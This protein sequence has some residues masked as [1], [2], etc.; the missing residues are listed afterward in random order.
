ML[1]ARSIV[2][3]KSVKAD[4]IDRATASEAGAYFLASQLGN[5]SITAKSMELVY[6][7]PNVE[8]NIPALYV[9]NTTDRH[10]FVIV[11]G[12]DCVMPIIAYSTD[13]CF[14]PNNIPPNMQWW[15]DG[16]VEDIVI[17]QNNE[18]EPAIEARESWEEL[19]EQR[20]PYFGSNSKAIIRLTTSTWNQ[21]PLYNNMCPVLSGQ[22]CVTGCVATAMAQILYYWKYPYVGKLSKE[23]SWHGQTLSANFANSYYNYDIMVD[24]LTSSSTTAQI[25]AVALLSYHCGISVDMDYDPEGSGAQS[26]D[27]PTALRRYFKYPKD[28]MSYVQRTS[29]Q[30]NNPNRTT[31]P[32]AKDT[33]WVMMLKNE[34]QTHRRPVYYSGYSPDNDGEV[35]AGHAFVCDGYNSINGQFHFNWGWGGAGDC[36]CNVYRAQL[37]ITNM[38]Y[39]FTDRHAVV[40]GIQ[41][42]A[43]T[44]EARAVGIET[45][46]DPFSSA[47][48]PNPASDHVTISYRLD[49]NTTSAE[50]VILD[51]TGRKV[52]AVTVTPASTQVTLSTANYRPGVYI[53]KLNGHSRKFVVQ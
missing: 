49:D 6:E 46:V 51:I 31:S 27:V 15:L 4:N 41:P 42:P 20:L 53:C 2:P 48:Y 30:Y 47:I 7:I 52:D 14:D 13:G 19:M 10:N 39:N 28:S 11:A 44:L 29:G 26:S 25:N 3:F 17:A 18:L 35:H 22:R 12:S 8:K 33:A 36:F 37:K 1:V 16:Q 38:G 24:E 50:M 32:N 45:V 43:D 40:I 23:Y 9:F 21:E 5:K 34:I